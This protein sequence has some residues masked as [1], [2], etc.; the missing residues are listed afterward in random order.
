MMRRLTIGG[1]LF[2]CLFVA[3]CVALL[4][5]GSNAAARE[6]SGVGAGLAAGSAT[7]LAAAPPAAPAAAPAA[8]PPAAPPAADN[9]ACTGCHQNRTREMTLASGEKLPLYVNPQAFAQSVHGE[10]GL[11]C[12]D[13]HT[14]ISGFPHPKLAAADRR[15]V[16]LDL[17]T[18]C[19]TCHA[20]QYQQAGDGVHQRALD[21]G[22]REA[23]VCSDCHNPH[24][25][26]PAAAR[27]KA[28]VAATCSACHT[29]I[30]DQFRDSVH[31]I[32]VAANNPDVPG[33]VDCHGVHDMPDP[34]AAAFRLKS[35]TEMCGACHTDAQRMAKYGLSTHV[36]DTY[37]ADFH[38]ATVTLFE[39][40]SPDQQTNKPVCFDCHG[41][42]DIRAVDDPLKG[43]QVKQNLLITC[44]K[45]HP[46][47]T[48]NFPDSWLS[49]YIPSPDKTP[50]VFAVDL[51]YKIFIPVVLGG[52]A[53]LV[54]LDA[55]RR[56]ANRVAAPG[57]SGASSTQA[58]GTEGGAE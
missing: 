21:A 33:C 22:I 32:A 23:A 5:P 4:A 12:T 2:G 9:S 40:R 13:C 19:R 55:G 47:A 3:L 37:L 53:V 27:T 58:L 39:R 8:A 34:M 15:Q 16:T 24:D 6:A 54:F 56:V 42:H 1:A 57:P 43:L 38:G 20:E 25:V 14:G 10:Q 51:F 49:H 7:F 41:V 36:L 29:Q 17:A 11:A 26:P 18:T 31:G 46:G 50:L 28:D 48:A 45:C 30:Y 44:Q 52:M 35:P